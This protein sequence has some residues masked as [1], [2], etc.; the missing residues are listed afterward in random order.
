MNTFIQVNSLTGR[1][2]VNVSD[3]SGIIEQGNKTYLSAWDGSDPMEIKESFD[4]ILFR[5]GHSKEF[6]I[7]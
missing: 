2:L 6:T 1:L 5:L 7:V 4:T 3:L